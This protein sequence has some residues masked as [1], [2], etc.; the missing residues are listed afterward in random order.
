MY[1]YKKDKN[2]SKKINMS[3]KNSKKIKDIINQ[4]AP[5]TSDI[6]ILNEYYKNQSNEL[7]KI[8]NNNKNSFVRVINDKIDTSITSV[9]KSFLKYMDSQPINSPPIAAYWT[10][11]YNIDYNK[12]INKFL[13]NNLLE[14]SNHKSISRMKVVELKELLTKIGIKPSG[15]KENLIDLVNKNFTEAKLNSINNNEQYFILTEKGLE[16]VKNIKQSIT[17]DLEFEDKCLELIQKN[18]FFE[19][20]KMICEFETRKNIPRGLGINWENELYKGLDEKAN[21]RFKNFLIE[22]TNII[23]KELLHYEKNIKSCI[24]FGKMMG[25]GFNKIKLLISRKTDI[26]VKKT[27]MNDIISNLYFKL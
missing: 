17:K 23:P 15:N 10:Y 5:K 11:E 12:I 4:E 22:E 18:N 21:N 16:I 19:A 9:E 24:I 14:I 13:D 1:I 6:N 2:N 3:E 27:N 26:D 8:H 7:R 25:A 20:Y